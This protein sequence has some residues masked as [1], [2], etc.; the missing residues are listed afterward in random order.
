MSVFGAG[1]SLAQ[2]YAELL[3]TSG[4]ERGVIGPHEHERIWD[5]HLLNCAVIEEG[6]PH[7]ARAIDVGS[8]A[9]LP[10]IP[11]A[12]ARPDLSLTLVEPLARRVNWLHEAVDALGLHDRVVI[13]HGRAEGVAIEAGDVVVSRAVAPLARLIPWSVRLCRADGLI[14]AIKGEGAM[15]ELTNVGGELVG[16]GVA[17]ARV[18]RFGEG[19]LVLPTTAVVGRR[20]ASSRTVRRST[21]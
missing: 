5:R 18:A 21:S 6:I 15:S 4:V 14:I 3:A 12:L 16:W 1:L 13:A 10:G 20:V 17:D 2:T 8:G 7:G 11:L 9:G 19:L